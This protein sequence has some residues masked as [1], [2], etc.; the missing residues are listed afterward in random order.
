MFVT[1]ASSERVGH[2]KARQGLA[3]LKGKFF[4][5]MCQ[6]SVDFIAGGVDLLD[7]YW[8]S[9]GH[10]FDTHWDAHGSSRYGVV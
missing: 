2:R 5:R 6:K 1:I 9:T 4:S 8:T 3:L 10:F 7:T